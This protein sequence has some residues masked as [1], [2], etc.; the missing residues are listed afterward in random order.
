MQISY[1]ITINPIIEFRYLNALVH[2]LNMQSSSD[3]D[4]IFYNQINTSEEEIFNQ[5]EVKPRFPY[6]FYSVEKEM[7]FNNY[8]VWDLYG[9]HQFLLDNDLVGDYFMSLHMEEF[10][11]FDYTEKAAAVLEKNGFDILL[12][13]LSRIWSHYDGVADIIK[14]KNP[15]EFDQYLRRTGYK[16][17]NHWCFTTK[18]MVFTRNWRRIKRNFRLRQIFGGS[19]QVKPTAEGFFRLPNYAAEDLVFMSKKFAHKYRWFDAPVKMYFSDIHINW[20]LE[21]VVKSITDFPVYFNQAKIYHLDHRRYYYHVADD[22]FGREL[23]AYETDSKILQAL[24][25]ALIQKYEKGLTP[26]E[27]RAILRGKYEAEG[28]QNI[29]FEFHS[30]NVREALAAEEKAT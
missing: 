15:D 19:R 20:S 8:P 7:F 24:Q 29:D 16:N 2:S 30:N 3:F 23:L 1:I 13:N 21:E 28:Y 9:F 5:L 18:N 6:K 12:G 14:T 10:L 25:A 17:A 26:Q 4:V 27:T 11:D 22:G